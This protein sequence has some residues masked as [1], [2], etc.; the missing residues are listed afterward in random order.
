MEVKVEVEPYVA[1]EP[2]MSCP[3]PL[4][5]AEHSV[6]ADSISPFV[7]ESRDSASLSRHLPI[8]RIARKLDV[9]SLLQ[10][11]VHTIRFPRNGTKLL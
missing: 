6:R 9:S 3:L 8:V 11:D 1:T 10:G 4:A 2:V 5:P 7:S